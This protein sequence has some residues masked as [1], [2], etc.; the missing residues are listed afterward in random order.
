MKYNK[1]AERLDLLGANG[2]SAFSTGMLR[3]YFPEE[4]EISLKKTI[5]RAV[6]NNV[7]QRVCRG[8]YVYRREFR[9]C[10]FKYEAV[11]AALR[12]GHISYVSLETALSEYSIISQQTLTYLTVMTTGRSQTYTMDY[13]MIEFTHTN[14]SESE[15]LLGTIMEPDRLLRLATPQLA[16]SDLRRVRRNLGLVNMETYEEIISESNF[17][18]GTN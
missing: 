5:E 14:R 13:G 8:A 16:L 7:L 11:A 12:N 1:F 2:I 4:S 9:R 10:R 6:K 3:A 17:P 18:D 15:I